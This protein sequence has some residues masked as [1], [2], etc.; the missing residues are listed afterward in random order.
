MGTNK[1][2]ASSVKNI[3]YAYSIGIPL[4]FCFIAIFHHFSH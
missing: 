4:G 3:S 2:Y 1:S